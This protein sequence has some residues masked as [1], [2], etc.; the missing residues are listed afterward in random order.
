M[1]KFQ[2]SGLFPDLIHREIHDPA[3]RILFLVYMAGNGSPE[4]L[5]DNTR[6]LLRQLFFSGRKNHQCVGGKFQL[7]L[8]KLC[9]FLQKL[10]DSSDDFSLFVDTEPGGFG[11]CLHLYVC[12]GFLD[13][14][15]A[16]ME[17]GDDDRLD[18]G[19]FFRKGRKTAV[20]A[21]RRCIFCR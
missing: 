14:L 8:H 18:P 16:F 1:T 12:A 11:S 10:G 15:P 17:V 13:H 19:A 6:H 9:L 5:N 3:E 7:P 4:Q 2:L 20:P 21:E